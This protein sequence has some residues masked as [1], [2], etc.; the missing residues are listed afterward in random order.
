MRIMRSGHG[1]GPCGEAAD[2]S[3]SERDTYDPKRG[4]GDDGMIRGEP[5]DDDS[6]LFGDDIWYERPPIELP[7]SAPGTRPA[8]PGLAC[9]E[10]VG[11]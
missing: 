4:D 2:A 7:S 6:E 5:L 3:A 1:A 9:C 8:K 10:S 11:E